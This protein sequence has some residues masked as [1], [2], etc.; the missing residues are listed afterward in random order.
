[1]TKIFVRPG[2]MADVPAIMEIIEAARAFLGA[3]HIDQWQ[4]TY[5]DQAAVEADIKAGTNRLL[6]V[7][8]QV[9]GNANLLPG[10]DPFYHRI[11]GAGWIGERPYVAIHRFAMSATVRGHGLTR[12]FLSN[13][14]S[15]VYAQGYRDVRID[16]HAENKIMQH[17]AESNGFTYRGIVYLDEPVPERMAYQLL[18]D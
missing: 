4:G 5:P 10:P 3:Q 7:D 12:V 6:I 16:T 13:L 18:L 2:Q 9:A 11:D 1:M 15:E 17:V 14:F 8:G